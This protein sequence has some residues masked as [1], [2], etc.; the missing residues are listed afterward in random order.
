MG[1][2]YKS[3]IHK[4]KVLE[5]LNADSCVIKTLSI[6]DREITKLSTSGLSIK[7]RNLFSILFYKTFIGWLGNPRNKNQA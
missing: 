7:N 5:I 6:S 2:W 1:V 3:Y 4:W